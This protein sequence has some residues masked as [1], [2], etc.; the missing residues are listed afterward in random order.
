[1]KKAMP[2][3]L[4]VAAL[5]LAMPALPVYAQEAAPAPAAQ[6]SDPE[7]QANALYQQ[8]KPETDAAKKLALG[9]QIVMEFF[10]TK[11]AES[12]GY[13][14]MFPQPDNPALKLEMS[15]TY[16][17]ASVATGKQGAYVEYA[18]GNLAT[19]E[20]DPRKALEYTRAYSQK[21][22]TGKFAEYVKK[23]A[24]AARYKLFDAAFKAKNYNEAATVANEAFAAKENEFLYSY[25]LTS[26]GLADLTAQG[27]TSQF[28]TKVGPWADRAAKYVESGQVPEGTDKAKWEAEKPKTLALL[29]KAQAVDRF[30]QAAKST[31]N[32]AAAF[33]PS[34][35]LLKKA[36][37]F[38][39][40]DPVIYYYMAQAYNTQYASAAEQYAALPEAD[41][42]GEAG[43]ATLAK[44]NAAAD[45]VIDAYVKVM[46][47]AGMDSPL[48]KT[49]QP[50]LEALWKFRH[51]EAPNGWQEEIKKVPGAMASK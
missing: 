23:A 8:W 12:V 48:S 14:G 26:A 6:A 31:P 21:F 10:G 29:Y 43:K 11:A 46:A 15:K 18:L 17:E 33:A 25:L 7:T 41:K 16:Y 32:D 51:E 9:K 35:D 44:V 1:M 28:V 39:P 3:M 24:A 30:L 45:Q 4:A 49:V 2:V 36:A 5:S 22:P 20:Q 47:Y 42:N 13:A 34:L 37:T 50:S 27:G 40:K 38:D 19:L